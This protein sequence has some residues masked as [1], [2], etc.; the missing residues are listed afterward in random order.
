MYQRLIL[1][2]VTTWVIEP[3]S[4]ICCAT[5]IILSFVF[6]YWLIGPYKEQLTI[7]HWMEVIN[8]LGITLTLVNNMFRS[9]LYVY[10]IPDQPPIPK[11]LQVFSYLD[12]I[13]SPIFVLLFM[14][15]LVPIFAKIRNATCW[16]KCCKKGEPEELESEE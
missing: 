4:R 16:H 15:V 8:F 9:F 13:A 3:I 14:K 6:V 1:V 10:D 7:L 5:P 12:S 11:S 2:V